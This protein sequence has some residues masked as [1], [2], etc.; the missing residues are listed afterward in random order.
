MTINE[1]SSASK[2]SEYSRNDSHQEENSGDSS[3]STVRAK[4]EET[5]EEYSKKF[6]E[7]GKQRRAKN[8]LAMHEASVAAS[9]WRKKHY[10][11]A[12]L[13]KDLKKQ[14]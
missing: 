13:D 3:S 2:R 7:N 14:V 8:N 1:L 6:I 5:V 4:E 12:D 11:R 9:E 10:G